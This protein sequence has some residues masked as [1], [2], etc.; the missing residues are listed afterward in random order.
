VVATSEGYP[1]EYPKG[2]PIRGLEELET[3]DDLQVF[4]SGTVQRGHDVVTA[5]GRVLAVCALGDDLEAARARAYAALERIE[6]RGMHY[7]R[8]IGCR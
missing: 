7:R 5:G 4:H 2:L 8:D 6:F 1:G 3:G